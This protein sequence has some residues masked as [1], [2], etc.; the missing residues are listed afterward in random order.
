MVPEP[1]C[2]TPLG[3]RPEPP[4]IQGGMGVGVS[5]WRLARAVSLAGGLG[6][7]SGV[8]LDT[9]V[10]RRLQLGDEGGRLR[11]ALGAFPFPEVADRVLRRY[12]RSGGIGERTAFAPVPLPVLAPRRPSVELTV[13]ANF[14]EVHLAKRGH[15]RPVGVNYMEKLQMSTLASVYGAM[16]AGVDYVLMGA[17]IPTGIPALLDTLAEG[18]RGEL[19]IEVDGDGERAFTASIDPLRRAHALRPGPL[20][21]RRPRFLAVVSS[22]LLAAYLARDAR[23][24]PDGFVIEGPVAGGHN[25][26]P[27]GKLELSPTGEPV[28]G[29]RDAVDLAKVAELGLPY[30]LAGGY[31][32]PEAL[33]GA[34]RAGA[35]GAQVGSAFALSEE[36]GLGTELKR[37]LAERAATGTL[38]VRTD[39][40]A[41]PTGFPLKVAELPDTAAEASVRN[42]RRRVCDVGY[43]RMPF[44]SAAG[45][46]DYRC[47]AEPVD[48]YTRKGGRAEDTAGRI[49]LCNGLISAVGLGQRRRRGTEPA[50]VTFG[51]DPSFLAPLVEAVGPVPYRAADV[52]RYL[53]GGSAGEP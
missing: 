26:P 33:A 46:I 23:S 15:A 4:L 25:A 29:P 13:V 39:P 32:S 6:V 8:G 27:R 2:G 30:W 5:G 24:R 50:V 7:V 17:G 35:S 52:V 19:P 47:P 44:R 12:Y 40:R 49:C 11:E 48:A 37:A 53:L 28:Y 36:S 21:L 1:G 43:L 31:A 41:S 38:R 45:G 34:L 18:G 51:G 42:G 14:A 9:L 10:A 20:R 16:L 3:A 22:H